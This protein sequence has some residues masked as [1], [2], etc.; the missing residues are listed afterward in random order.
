MQMLDIVPHWNSCRFFATYEFSSY[1]AERYHDDRALDK[2][3]SE[4]TKIT[5][6]NLHT[7]I[8]LIDNF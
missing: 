1:G 7:N 4:V 2:K 5:R 8:D 6:R 3:L